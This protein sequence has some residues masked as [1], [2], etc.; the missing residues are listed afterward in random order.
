MGQ[1]SFI[2][3]IVN[4]NDINSLAFDMSHAHILTHK[5]AFSCVL[6]SHFFY[7]H[8]YVFCRFDRAQQRSHLT[9][10]HR[11]THSTLRHIFYI[12]YK[13]SKHDLWLDVC[14]CVRYFMALRTSSDTSV[15]LFFV[16]RRFECAKISAR[17]QLQPP[18]FSLFRSSVV[19]IIFCLLASC[20]CA[21]CR[22]LC[23][24]D[25]IWHFRLSRSLWRRS[26]RS[27]K[28]ERTC[29]SDDDND[30]IKM[31]TTRKCIFMWKLDLM[32]DAP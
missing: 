7:V 30:H 11:R 13:Y 14:E 26:T 23:R 29:H 21:N 16:R 2:P 5:R 12:I 9:P 6:S 15:S 17:F 1:N 24:N 18:C 4:W 28:D 22:R 19:V 32:R 31:Y 20:V 3:W 27:S 8:S 25:I 10:T